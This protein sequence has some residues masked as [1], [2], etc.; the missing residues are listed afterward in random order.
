MSFEGD[1]FFDGFTF[2]TLGQS[3][4]SAQLAHKPNFRGT[5]DPTAG[6]V[7]Y[8]NRATAENDHL[9]YVNDN[10]TVVIRTDASTKLAEGEKRKSVRLE[11]KDTVDFGS[12]VLFDVVRAPFG[13]GVW[14]ACASLLFF[15]TRRADARAQSGCQCLCLTLFAM[16][17]CGAVSAMRTGLTTVKLCGFSLC[18][19]SRLADRNQQDMSVLSFHAL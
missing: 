3:S 4:S 1:S 14:P 10:G 15:F 16:A 5:E 19:A 2:F 6:Q 11:S 17:E 18:R 12:L 9:A 8:V 13:P 7:E